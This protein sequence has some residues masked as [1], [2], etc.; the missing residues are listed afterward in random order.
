MKLNTI[1]LSGAV[2]CA[3]A[4]AA[5]AGLQEGMPMVKPGPEHEVLKHMVGT[6]D[7][8]VEVMGAK[9]KG[10]S[11]AKL[12]LGDMW[13]LSDFQ[14]TVMGAPFTGHEVF[15]WD[16]QKK[17][18]VGCWVDSMSTAFNLSEGTWDPAAKAMTMTGTT[19]DPM[20]GQTM[21]SVIKVTDSDHHVF[22]MHMGGTDSPP[23]MTITYTRKK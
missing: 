17:K 11:V 14:G 16:S 3:G 18:Y 13:I 10:S 9:E 19:P 6:W 23:M 21:T 4:F 15:G 1:V 2:L 22:E 7:A 5:R 20:T 12:A 8:E